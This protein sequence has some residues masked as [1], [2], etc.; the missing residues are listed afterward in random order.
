MTM[1]RVVVFMRIMMLV[2]AARGHGQP[3]EREPYAEPHE[4]IASHRE[5]FDALDENGD[6]RLAHGEI[7]AGSADE[8]HIEAGDVQ[9]F[10]EE[11]DTDKDGHVGWE[12]YMHALLHQEF[13]N[14]IPTEFDGDMDDFVRSANELS[15]H[16]QRLHRQRQRKP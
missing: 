5:E 1:A 10:I 12:E 15:E 9:A 6:G 7:E 14:E 2:L 8:E 11:L 4:E 3:P 16:A 13:E